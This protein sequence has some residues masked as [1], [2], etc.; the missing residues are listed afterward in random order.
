MHIALCSKIGIIP[1]TL[2]LAQRLCNAY[3][4]PQNG[5]NTFAKTVENKSI[6]HSTFHTLDETIEDIWWILASLEAGFCFL[7]VCSML[8]NYYTDESIPNVF[9]EPAV[10]SAILQDFAPTV[11]E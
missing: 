3:A 6:T 5:K 11:Q 1:N 7:T 2:Q 8:G 4:V 9:S 10:V